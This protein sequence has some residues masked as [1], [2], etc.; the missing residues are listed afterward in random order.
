M[1]N[2]NLRYWKKEPTYLEDAHEIK[3]AR[4]FLDLISKVLSKADNEE[5]Y[6]TY[7]NK[8][9][10][11]SK[12]WMGKWLQ[13]Y[14]V[15]PYGHKDGNRKTVEDI[16]PTAQSVN[17]LTGY[18]LYQDWIYASTDDDMVEIIDGLRED[19]GEV[20]NW[21]S[22]MT[23]RKMLSGISQHDFTIYCTLSEARMWLGMELARIRNKNMEL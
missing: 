23:N 15:S 22:Y 19:I 3:D 17:D 20:L 2:L 16:T 1:H 4:L 6:L 7:A 9:I 5:R 21:V 11:L 8:S 14:E 18:K 12:M 13:R 10:M